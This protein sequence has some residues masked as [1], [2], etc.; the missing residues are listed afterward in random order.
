MYVDYNVS[1]VD[2]IYS[3]QNFVLISSGRVDGV[4]RETVWSEVSYAIVLTV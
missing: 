4:S 1:S 3:L 2:S